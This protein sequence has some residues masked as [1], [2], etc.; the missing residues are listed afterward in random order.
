MTNPR[1]SYLGLLS[2]ANDIQAK[3]WARW[4]TTSKV[5]PILR[6][7]SELSDPPK[8]SLRK[9]VREWLSSQDGWEERLEEVSQE[10]DRL[11]DSGVETVAITDDSYPPHLRS[12][13]IPPLVLHKRGERDHLAGI[14]IVGSRNADETALRI[15]KSFASW[16][17]DNDV[18]VITGMAKGADE[19]AASACI[20]AGGTLI[21]SIPG[22]PEDIVP[23]TS[24]EE[25]RGA[26][27]QGCLVTEVTGLDDIQKSSFLRRNRL[28]SGLSR[29]VVVTAARDS[30]GTFNQL[31][32]AHRQNR[33]SLVLREGAP[34]DFSDQ[35]PI[36]DT[37]YHL[38][39]ASDLTQKASR[40]WRK[41][42]VSPQT[43]LS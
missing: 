42:V 3:N 24:A 38:S 37:P 40:L 20:E 27:D 21:G 12:I 28:T 26:I 5:D 35:V 15:T 34:E 4:E 19:A 14:A 18:P 22:G 25:Y 29:V 31:G 1:D 7:W 33:P 30:G 36:T 39:E 9:R 17:S 8:E 41:P 13:P 32:W 2:T 23:R 11:W 10:L 43:T 16:L 6:E